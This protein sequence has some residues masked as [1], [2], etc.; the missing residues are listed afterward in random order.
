[1][2]FWLIQLSISAAPA[3]ND[4][5]GVGAHQALTVKGTLLLVQAT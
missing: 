1:M 4:Q 5:F 3:E 2:L